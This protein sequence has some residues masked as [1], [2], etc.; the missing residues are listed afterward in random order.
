LLDN[1]PNTFTLSGFQNTH[2]RVLNWHQVE[3]RQSKLSETLFDRRM[4]VC[5]P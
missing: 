3:M 1:V 4:R 2:V 5:L